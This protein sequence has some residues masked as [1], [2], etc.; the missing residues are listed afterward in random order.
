MVRAL[1]VVMSKDP[2]KL[3]VP[4]RFNTALFMKKELYTMAS[5]EGVVDEP[6]QFYL[7]N[8]IAMISYAILC[9]WGHVALYSFWTSW[10]DRYRNQR[11]SQ[12]GSSQTYWRISRIW[13]ILLVLVFIWVT[14]S[15]INVILITGSMKNYIEFWYNLASQAFEALASSISSACSL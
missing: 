10:P 4:A 7:N 3:P 15:G 1:P 12:E 13:L 6:E 9:N 14:C 2:R 11:N 8:Y 5:H